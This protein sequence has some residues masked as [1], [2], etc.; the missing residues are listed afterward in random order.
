MTDTDKLRI[1]QL[2]DKDDYRL[3]RI[4]IAAACDGKGLEAVLDHKECPRGDADEKKKFVSDQKKASN[5]IVAALSDKALRVVRANIGNPHLMLTKLDERYDSKS[6]AARIAKM[7]ELI[8]MRYDN[9]KRSMG[10]HIDQ[11]AGLLEQLHSMNTP[12]PD[13]LSI[14]LLISSLHVE[15]LAPISAAVKTLSDADVT[16]EKVTARLLEE[17]Q[18]L[19]DRIKIQER[20]TTLRKSCELCKKTG[21]EIDSCWLNPRN[22]KNRLGINSKGTRSKEHSSSADAQIPALVSQE[23]P[24]RNK[25]SRAAVARIM[26]CKLYENEL[27]MLDS[28]T[29]AH[30][31]NNVN[32]LAEA[33]RCN[34][35]IALGDNSEINASYR[36][37]RTVTWASKNGE[38][39]VHLTGT[40]SAPKLAMSLLSVPALTAKGLCVLFLPTKALIMDMKDDLS[41]VGTAHKAND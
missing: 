7:T 19:K 31:T 1:K 35:P 16:W 14:A 11:M 6:T 9:L 36:G 4:R 30:M 38:T 27:M 39:D 8:S 32:A 34:V 26:A 13:E 24:K 20:A 17:H 29:T 21:H 28:G 18:A 10:V 12:I 37:T 3:W 33:S 41:I 2:D 22:P 15:E 5:I 25:K 23:R 40:L